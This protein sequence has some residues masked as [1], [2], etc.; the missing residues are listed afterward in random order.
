MAETQG[1]STPNGAPADKP[2]APPRNPAETVARGAAD[3]AK[4]LADAGVAAT[5]QAERRSF[6]AADDAARRGAEAADVGLKAGQEMA[7]TG[8]DA[9]RRAGEHAADF[10]RSSF[11]PVVRMQSEFG[12]LVDQI[13]REGPLAG[14]PGAGLAQAALWGHPAADLKETDQGLELVVEL[15]GLTAQDIELRLR[16]D[17]L[18]LSGHKAEESNRHA[19]AYR[20]S[21]RRFGR[22]ERSFILPPDADRE[23]IDASFRDGLLRVTIAKAD[24][25]KADAGLI[26]IKG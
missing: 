5:A 7:R 8:Q 4:D 25:S 16:G 11:N 23:R 17:T 2:R 10:W 6:A 19:G 15:P 21:E 26:P 13:W 12:R 3:S 1:S 14:L 9:V 18:L 24:P 22:F 20:M